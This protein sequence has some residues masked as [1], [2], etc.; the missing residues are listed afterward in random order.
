[1]RYWCV[2]LLSCA[3]VAGWAQSS[4]P[5]RPEVARQLNEANEMRRQGRYNEA[6][7]ILLAAARD[8][9]AGMEQAVI[10][11]DL[12]VHYTTVGRYGDGEQTLK[13]AIRILKKLPGADAEQVL[14]NVTL[15]LAVVYIDLNRSREAEKLD[16]H[17]LLATLHH[18]EDRARAKTML[19]ALASSRGRFQEAERLYNELLAFWME[20]ARAERC[21]PAIATALNNLGV[22]ALWQG[23]TETAR[24][25]LERSFEIWR[26]LEGPAGPGRM[27]SMAN[28][29]S[30][31]MEAKRYDDAALWLERATAAG[32]TTYGELHPIT[33]RFQQLY[34]EALKKAGHKAAAR[35]ASRVAAEARAMMRTMTRSYTVDYRDLGIPEA[36]RP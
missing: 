13:R 32:R 6:E 24:E 36:G 30:V 1:M 20:P 18:P 19:A 26:T 16:L 28:V 2:V 3:A 5:V 12:G 4:A 23:R 7:R 35:E 22:L 31:Y 15:D 11:S 21:R 10:L 17:R 34:A 25:R 8:G 27:R 33:V 29:A 9:A 14:T